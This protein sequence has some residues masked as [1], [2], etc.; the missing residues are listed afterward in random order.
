MVTP[1]SNQSSWL[2]GTVCTALRATHAVSP[3]HGPAPLNC[4]SVGT[5]NS[6]LHTFPAG[7]PVFG[8]RLRH[9][10]LHPIGASAQAVL[11]AI[12]VRLVEL[13]AAFAARQALPILL[14]LVL[15]LFL[16]LRA[17]LLLRAPAGAASRVC[18]RSCMLLC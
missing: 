1:R 2:H 10:G 15:L 3:R 9:P 17:M 4:L 8:D 14:L 16:L 13:A 7:E 18:C 6:L 12:D 5:G 11:P